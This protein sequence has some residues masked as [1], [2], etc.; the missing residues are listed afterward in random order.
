MN[1]NRRGIFV[2]GFL[3]LA[4]LGIGAA[5]LPVWAHHPFPRESLTFY[6][7]ICGQMLLAS[8]LFPL[9][10]ETRWS[11][12]INLALL[13]PIDELGGLL[14]N[15]DQSGILKCWLCVGI[16]IAGLGTWN[17]ILIQDRA[18]LGIAA[19]A[20]FM[21]AGGSVLDYLRWEAASIAGGSGSFSPISLPPCACDL[22]LHFDP[23]AWIQA[24]VPAV[25]ATIWFFIS[26]WANRPSTSLHNASKGPVPQP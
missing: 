22:I 23:K 12:A 21:T 5:G 16:W 9:L 2:W 17:R 25:L 6:E 24:S 19:L 7:L 18:K 26:R 1:T 14:S 4:L 8:M 11:L 3:N 13:V 20:I 15:L 10:A